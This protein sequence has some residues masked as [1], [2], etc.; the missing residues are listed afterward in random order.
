MVLIHSDGNADRI[1]G[2][3]PLATMHTKRALR[4]P[5]EQHPAIEL[6]LQAELFE[7]PEKELRMTA[8]LE[9][10]ERG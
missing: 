2:N 5:R 1:A 3:D 6:D 10:R 7:S 9:K 8:F 4:A